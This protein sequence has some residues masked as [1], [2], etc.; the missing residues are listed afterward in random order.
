MT[1]PQDNKVQNNA[2]ELSVQEIA[3]LNKIL[4]PIDTDE[5]LEW[6]VEDISDEQIGEISSILFDEKE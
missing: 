5:G 3:N 1:D 6:W 4:W 2:K